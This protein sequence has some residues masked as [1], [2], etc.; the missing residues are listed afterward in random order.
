MC[1]SGLKSGIALLAAAGSLQGKLLFI[2]SSS[3]IKTGRCE[4]ALVTCRFWLYD[5]YS[6][7]TVSGSTG[8]LSS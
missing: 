4:G 3:M 1:C 5:E 2:G 7:C 6:A 8:G